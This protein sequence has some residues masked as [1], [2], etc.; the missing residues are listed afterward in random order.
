MNRP[1]DVMMPDRVLPLVR[2]NL[3]VQTI[4]LE[5][6]IKRGTHFHGFSLFRQ[7]NNCQLFVSSGYSF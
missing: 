4:T 6:Q 1:L 7:N 2:R 3:K 5:F